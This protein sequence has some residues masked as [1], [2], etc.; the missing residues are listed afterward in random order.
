[1]NLRSHSLLSVEEKVRGQGSPIPLHP[2]GKGWV[3]MSASVVAISRTGIR[4]DTLGFK[5]KGTLPD[6]QCR[7][8]VATPVH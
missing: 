7:W 6:V 5:P 8:S 2:S 1:L 4:V 3:A